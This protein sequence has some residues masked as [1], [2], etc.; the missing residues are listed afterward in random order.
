M[1][2]CLNDMYYSFCVR[3]TI[4]IAMEELLVALPCGLGNSSCLYSF[5]HDPLELL[6]AV[7]AISA[8]SVVIEVGVNHQATY[9]SRL[10]KNRSLL[11][12]GLEPNPAV[13]VQHAWHPRFHLLPVAAA[14]V[15][16]VSGSPPS[17][18]TLH[19]T[20]SSAWAS[21]LKPQRVDDFLGG[22]LMRGV[23]VPV[24]PLAPV[25]ERAHS[26]GPIKL[27]SIDAQGA[28]LSIIDSGGSYLQYVNRIVLECQDVPDTR[29]AELAYQNQPTK[30]Q[31][32]NH[33]AGLGFHL[34]HCWATGAFI[35]EDCAFAQPAAL[36]GRPDCFGAELV[37]A[38]NSRGR[39]LAAGQASEA[40]TVRSLARSCCKGLLVCWDAS[41][42]F[43][44]DRCCLYAFFRATGIIL[45]RMANMS[46]RTPA[47]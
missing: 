45:D 17:R 6:P 40:L 16:Y 11:L 8:G 25:L 29:R 27:L 5:K 43:T 21:L 39:H 38:V 36:L 24:M 47:A 12:I 28:E 15:P 14:D 35:Q 10:V 4:A 22:T 7:G 37:D 9:F 26:F 44:E 33:M 3:I 2:K 13:G 32:I 46:R 1:L 30:K 23:Q 42:G 34:E 20:R 18:T 19:V 41:Q 31:I